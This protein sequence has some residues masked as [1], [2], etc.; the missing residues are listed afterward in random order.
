VLLEADPQVLKAIEVMPKAAT[1][2]ATF[3]ANNK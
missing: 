3:A 2:V 1:M